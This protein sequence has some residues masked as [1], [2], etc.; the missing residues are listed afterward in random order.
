MKNPTT[1]LGTPIPES[2][3]GI[4]YLCYFDIEKKTIQVTQ[5]RLYVNSFHALDAYANIPNPESQLVTG[6]NFAD[7]I[8]NLNMLHN[9]L[10][11]KNWLEELSNCL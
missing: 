3:R 6:K 8:L 11:D 9:N 2:T 10:K 4:L 1:I 7:L 5:E